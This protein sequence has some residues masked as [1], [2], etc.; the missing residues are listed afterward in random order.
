MPEQAPKMLN[1]TI[2]G[3]QISVP[4]GTL[5]WKAAQMAGIEVPIYCYHPKMPPLGACRMCFVE[6]EKAP[7]AHSRSVGPQPLES[8]REPTPSREP[9]AR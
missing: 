4:E 2:D 6:I 5:V 7:N 3:R 8:R 9:E 1:V